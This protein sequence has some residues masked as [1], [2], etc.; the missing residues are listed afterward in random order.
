MIRRTFLTDDEKQNRLILLEDLENW[1]KE[2]ANS[3]PK[4]FALERCI[5]VEYLSKCIKWHY[6]LKETKTARKA[7]V[8]TN[9]RQDNFPSLVAVTKKPVQEIPASSSSGESA[10]HIKMRASSIDIAGNIAPTLL[11]Q[12]LSTLGALNV[13]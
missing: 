1:R 6:Q 4:A 5:D 11:A 3:S 13:L 10:I 7:T 9:C 12:L 2:A 8:K